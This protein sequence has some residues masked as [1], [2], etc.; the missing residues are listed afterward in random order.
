[1]LQRAVVVLS[2]RK[3][4]MGSFESGRGLSVAATAATVLIVLLNGVL[5]WQMMF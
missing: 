3:A 2:S 5:I 1:M 4:V